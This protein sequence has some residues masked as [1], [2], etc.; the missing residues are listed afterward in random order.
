MRFAS[1]MVYLWTCKSGIVKGRAATLL[2][3]GDQCADCI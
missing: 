1:L 2:A 3:P